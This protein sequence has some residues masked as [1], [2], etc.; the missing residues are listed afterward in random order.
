MTM[1]T[2][3][4]LRIENIIPATIHWDK[5]RKYKRPILS[6]IKDSL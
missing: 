5:V 3:L 4:G 2:L 1:M 6:E